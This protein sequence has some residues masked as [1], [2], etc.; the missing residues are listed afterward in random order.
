MYAMMKKR[1]KALYILQY[2]AEFI[3]GDNTFEAVV[4]IDILRVL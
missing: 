2:S 1:Y 3:K 4:G